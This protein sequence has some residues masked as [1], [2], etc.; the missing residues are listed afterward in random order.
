MKIR[1][2][3]AITSY[4]FAK[5]MTRFEARIGS[6]YGHAPKLFSVEKWSDERK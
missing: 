5:L 4:F 3:P 1:I 2:A 6:D